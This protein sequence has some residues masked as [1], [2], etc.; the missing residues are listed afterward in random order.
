MTQSSIPQ[1]IAFAGTRRISSGPLSDVAVAAK[2]AIAAGEPDP[3]LIFDDAT[4]QVIDV[5][6]R[7][8]AADVIARVSGDST[9]QADGVSSADADESP[10]R[11]GD[12]ARGRGRPK[13]GVVAREVTLLPRHWEWLAT[14]PGGAFAA[15]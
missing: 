2:Q 11:E 6:F 10:Y 13:L 1:C 8:T 4:S 7:G 12:A 14:Q 5:D 15:V 3:V 9:S